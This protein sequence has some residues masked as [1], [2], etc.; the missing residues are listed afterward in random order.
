MASIMRKNLGLDNAARI[1][2]NLDYVGF[3]VPMIL[4]TSLPISNMGSR[5]SCLSLGVISGRVKNYLSI[6]NALT[7]LRFQPIS[8]MSCSFMCH[9]SGLTMRGAAYYLHSQRMYLPITPS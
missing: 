8:M 4:F 3:C 5:N 1:T 6:E 2:H 9:Y 7:F